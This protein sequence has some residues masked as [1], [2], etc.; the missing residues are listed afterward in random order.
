M[1]L[2]FHT[3]DHGKP[4][5]GA[6]LKDIHGYHA[7]VKEKQL[8]CTL[9]CHHQ[10]LLC[11]TFIYDALGTLAFGT[12]GCMQNCARRMSEVGRTSRTSSVNVDIGPPVERGTPSVNVDYPIDDYSKVGS[13]VDT[14]KD[15]V[16]PSISGKGCAWV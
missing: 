5:Q 10:L 15:G 13:K 14:N 12:H 9:C 2:V 11:A 4:D 7:R 16:A 3:Q 1:P 6:R 8:L